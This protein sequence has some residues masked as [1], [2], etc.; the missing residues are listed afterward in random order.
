M[1]AV[2]PLPNLQRSRFR[3]GESCLRREQLTFGPT[4]II[5]KPF[6]PRLIT[7]VAPAVAKAAMD[8]GVAKA[9][10]S[11]WEAYNRVLSDRLGRD[12]KFIRLLNE[13]ASQKPQRI[14]FTE[15]DQYR[16]LKA[17]EILI[18]GGTAKPV[19]LGPKAKIERIIEEYRLSRQ[20]RDC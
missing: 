13:N 8:S 17:A 5:P 19:L 15:G 14:V 3:V 12:D 1:A 20:C 2:E 18:N 6:D 9:P 7:T 10:I 16:I 4:Y 11:D